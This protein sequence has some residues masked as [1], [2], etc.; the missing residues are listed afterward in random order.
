MALDAALL[1]EDRQI[2]Y[3]FICGVPLAGEEVSVRYADGLPC[4]RTKYLNTARPFGLII[5]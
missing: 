1:E 2:R 5:V 3:C 4:C